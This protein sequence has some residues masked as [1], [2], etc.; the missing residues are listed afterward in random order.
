MSASYDG[1]FV[2]HC[3]K[4]RSQI[5]LIC[6]LTGKDHVD[7]ILSKCFYH[8]HPSIFINFFDKKYML[9]IVYSCI[10]INHNQHFNIVVPLLKKKKR[11]ISQL[12]KEAHVTLSHLKQ[13]LACDIF[14]WN[15]HM[16]FSEVIMSHANWRILYWSDHFHYEI[17]KF[18]WK[19][20]QNITVVFVLHLKKNRFKS[21]FSFRF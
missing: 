6:F 13:Y 3:M 20:Q 11:A 18:T 9:Y 19:G 5:S 4:N 1:K 8:N 17:Y 15:N 14:W 21:Y 7:A 10:T 2:C 16:L 12:K